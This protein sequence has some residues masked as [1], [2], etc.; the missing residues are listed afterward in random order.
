MKNALS[1]YVVLGIKTPVPF[2]IDVLAS[3]PFCDGKTSTDFIAANFNDWKQAVDE[4]D[5]ALIAC[6]IDEISGK[7]RRKTSAEATTSQ[8]GPWDTLGNWRL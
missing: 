3:V 2:L 6:I 4:T 8:A 7:K 1:Q 5:F